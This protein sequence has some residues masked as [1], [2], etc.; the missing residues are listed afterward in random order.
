M[1]GEVPAEKFRG[2]E[3]EIP[4]NA[5]RSPEL[6]P[7]LDV[8]MPVKVDMLV[9]VDMPAKVDMSVDLNMPEVLVQTGLL[10]EFIRPEDDPRIFYHVPAF[11]DL[12]MF[13]RDNLLE[14]GLAIKDELTLL[15][16]AAGSHLA[17][18]EVALRLLKDFKNLR[19]VTFIYTEISESAHQR[20]ANSLK[21]LQ[22]RGLIKPLKIK[23][24]K[25]FEEKTFPGEPGKEYVHEYEV[26]AFGGAKQIVFRYA[27][28]RS[29]EDIYRDEYLDEA[30]IPI[31][32]DSLD[33]QTYSFNKFTNKIVASGDQRKAFF[34][35][36]V[37]NPKARYDLLPGT[38]RIS[39]EAYG[40]HED[41]PEILQED[42][43]LG[44][45]K[46]FLAAM[47]SPDIELYRNLTVSERAAV[48]GF[49]MSNF[50]FF[51]GLKVMEVD[52]F[53]DYD[54]S[55]LDTPRLQ[56]LTAVIDFFKAMEKID[57][58]DRV[59]PREMYAQFLKVLLNVDESKF[60]SLYMNEKLIADKLDVLLN[61]AASEIGDTRVENNYGEVPFLAEA[62]EKF[63]PDLKPKMRLILRGKVLILGMAVSRNSLKRIIDSE[64]GDF[65]KQ[66]LKNLKELLQYAEKYDV[67]EAAELRQT[68]KNYCAGK[69]IDF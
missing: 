28:N 63:R 44:K 68:L 54:Y 32:H 45:P 41:D 5:R 48:H 55:F 10:D 4:G 49:V 15:Y 1:A 14:E 62:V 8:D 40:C 38:Y 7:H 30:D 2:P 29:G 64:K 57:W 20:F 59:S 51:E 39:S 46:G 69:G 17:P 25:G 34:I 42:D 61:A 60:K 53:A 6:N 26:S 37:R 47:Y 35:E 13:Y 43:H 50:G 12:T 67:S 36:H 19:K 18:L 58:I 52:E 11:A 56:R 22:D 3:P 21:R 16:P 31:S 27:M 9:K 66:F 23:G 24:N 33:E 65:L